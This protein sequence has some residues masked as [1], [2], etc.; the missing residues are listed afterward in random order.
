[1]PNRKPASREV[2][3]LEVFNRGAP[4]AERRKRG[5][6]MEFMAAHWHCILPVIGIAAWLLSTAYKH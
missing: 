6:K 3:N 4:A 5:E 2:F 1:M